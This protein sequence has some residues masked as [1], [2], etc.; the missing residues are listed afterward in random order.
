MS[1][2]IGRGFWSSGLA[3]LPRVEP[4]VEG[5]Q[6]ADWS[7]RRIRNVFRALALIVAAAH[8]F[9]A[10]NAFGPDG[11]SYV[12]VARAYLHHDW[13]MAINA[14]WSPLYSWFLAI[15]LG[16]TR[17]GL[18]SEIPVIHFANLLLFLACMA[19]FE[20]FW[21]RVVN[22]ARMPTGRKDISSLPASALWILG[23]A[24]FTW[25]SAVALLPLVS[26]DLC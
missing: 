18:R 9:V 14:Y 8:S 17:P 21:S 15:V 20:F 22:L 19:S 11:R 4:Y 10:R 2:A 7:C 5:T 25:E 12:E 16:V 1:D 23:Y 3:Q 13:A 6:A 24:V 26:T